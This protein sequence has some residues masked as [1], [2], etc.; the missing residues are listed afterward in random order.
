MHCEDDARNETG[1]P[2]K[3]TIAASLAS[4]PRIAQAK[5]L[6]LDTIADHQRNITGIRP[7]HAES[8]QSYHEMLAEFRQERGAPLFYP[9]I[10]SGIGKGPLV[11]LADG[12]IKY[13]FISGIG[14]HH[15]GH[16]HPAL[17]EAMLD[18]ALQ[19]TVMQGNLE[20]NAESLEVANLL[21]EGANRK[22]ARLKHCFLST[23]GAMANENAFKIIFQKNSP[24][25]RILAFE[26]C[27]A[28]RT[29]AMAQITDKPLY[30]AGLPSILSVDYIPFFDPS[31][32]AESIKTACEHLGRYLERYPGKHAAMIFELVLGEGGFYAGSRDFFAALMDILKQ[33]SIAVLVDEIQTFSRTTELFAF[34][35]LGLDAYADV[36]TVGKSAQVCATLFTEEFN[37]RPGLLSQTFIS[38]TSALFAA[39]VII[40]GL[41]EG[42]YF[43]T[44]GKVARLHD[45]FEKRLIGIADR[46]PELVAGPYG[47]GVMI[48]FT[49]FNGDAEK[50]KRFI[51][52]LFHAGVICFY[53]G[54]DMSRVRFL[55][56]VGAVTFEDIDAVA[57]IVEETLLR[58]LGQN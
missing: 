33:N 2:M 52:A 16:S 58:V 57:S 54:H 27:F 32:P 7:P 53:A 28:G 6:M 48:A 37:P 21:L 41:I 35:Y 10:G 34:Q 15:W 25:D 17:I 31:R 4:D 30:R 51:H 5:K 18:A 26:G 8:Q 44:D 3:K 24:A 20:Q 13:D 39:K 11:E 49:P 1:S 50:V 43:G 45:H 36:V 29:L 23:S 46:Y 55:I 47:I 38:S 40:R 12:S 9:Y 56:P 19:D 22:G 14:V 42:D